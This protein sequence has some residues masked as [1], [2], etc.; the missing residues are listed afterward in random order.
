MSSQMKK[1]V[2]LENTEIVIKNF[3]DIDLVPL[4]YS[5]ERLWFIDQLRGSSNYHMFEVLRVKGRIQK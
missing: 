3:N 2:A 5:Q 4:S 1:T